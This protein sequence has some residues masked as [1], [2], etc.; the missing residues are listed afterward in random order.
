MKTMIYGALLMLM[1]AQ[2]L[3]GNTKENAET[4]A[5]AKTLAHSL[6]E[7]STLSGRF[8]QKIIDADGQ[9]LQETE[10]KFKVLR[11]GYFL[12]HVDPPYEQLIIGTPETL[13]V[14]DP[15]LEQMTVHQ[16]N[17]FSGT[18][19]ALISGDVSSITQQYSVTQQTK[20]KTQTFTL[21]QFENTK[22]DFESLSF[23]FSLNTPKA[24][25]LMGMNFTDRLGQRTE[26]SF[27]K[28]EQ[29]ET[30]AQR[31]FEFEPPADTDIILDD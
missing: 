23:R 17:V 29:N 25:V 14:Y 7:I 30:L 8:L 1:C 10:G 20:N 2:T 28:L 22:S 4:T 16:Q 19:A 24:S 18:P 5:V 15:D 31:A 9:T 3:A 21:K 11:P 26:V 6:T 12:W 27:R 13:K